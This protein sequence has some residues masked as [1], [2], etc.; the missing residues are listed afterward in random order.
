MMSANELQ[1]VSA[2]SNHH[3]AELS[4]IKGELANYKLFVERV[5]SLGNIPRPF[6]TII[7]STAQGFNE[8]Y[9]QLEQNAPSLSAQRLDRIFSE[10]T[11]A[12][13]SITLLEN[14]VSGIDESVQN[15]LT[16]VNETERYLKE[17]NLLIHG[18]KGFPVRPSTSDID[19]RNR[20][21][22]LFIEFVCNKLNELLRGKNYKCISN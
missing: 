18:L 13:S 12:H 8:V 5:M 6:P 17:W 10:A 4:S 9:K 14:R 1:A 7:P 20:Y 21:E 3:A 2:Q 22:F 15:L 11:A 19:G 16:S